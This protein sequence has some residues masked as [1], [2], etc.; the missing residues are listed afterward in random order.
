MKNQK[1]WNDQ[2]ESEY[3]NTAASPDCAVWEATPARKYE[4]F[5]ESVEPLMNS[6]LTFC[7]STCKFDP[8]TDRNS[9]TSFTCTLCYALNEPHWAP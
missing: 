1:Y 6:E 7:Q 3:N 9:R 4:R 8:D 2:E 5:I